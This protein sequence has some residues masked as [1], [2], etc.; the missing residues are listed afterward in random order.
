MSLQFD[1]KALENLEAVERLRSD[2][3][4]S[5]DC[6]ANAVANRAYY[7]VYLAVATAREQAAD[8][9][10]EHVPGF[11]SRI[12]DRRPVRWTPPQ[13]LV[14][15]YEGRE[16]TLQVFNADA[17][18]QRHLLETIEQHRP[19]LEAAAGGSIVVIFHSVRQ[20]RDR[21]ADVL[22]TSFKPIA[23]PREAAP[24]AEKCIDAPDANGPHRKVA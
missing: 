1:E 14:G 9:K 4:G 10:R 23:A 13:R 16:R 11:V 20:T 21:Y 12:L 3:E 6:L 18:D 17:A 15:D 8:M 19:M 22:R 24:P 7:A 2:D 5:R